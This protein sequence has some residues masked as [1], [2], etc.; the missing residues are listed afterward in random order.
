MLNLSSNPN[1]DMRRTRCRRI[2]HNLFSPTSGQPQVKLGFVAQYFLEIPSSGGMMMRTVLADDSG[3]FN[4]L[5]PT[6][7]FS[8]EDFQ[9]DRETF[10]YEISKFGRGAAIIG[11]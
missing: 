9:T 10:F 3:K 2:S 6:C 7:Q 1:T 5:L 4:I 8:P 11:E